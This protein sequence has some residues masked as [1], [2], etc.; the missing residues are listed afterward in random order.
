MDYGYVRACTDVVRGRVLGLLR[1]TWYA[2]ALIFVQK[3]LCFHPLAYITLLF[4][5]KCY[6]QV[7]STIT[8]LSNTLTFSVT[9][10]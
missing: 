10:D 1:I 3:H 5:S 9:Q 8:K 4:S 2:Q 6:A 7:Q